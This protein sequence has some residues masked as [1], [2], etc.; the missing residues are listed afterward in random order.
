MR[1]HYGPIDIVGDMSEERGAVAVFQTFENLTN[2]V[3]RDGDR[4]L[5]GLRGML[6]TTT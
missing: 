1:A 5:T 2:I 4:I 3:G 6:A